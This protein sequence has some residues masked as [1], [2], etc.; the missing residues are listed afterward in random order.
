MRSSRF[1]LASALA[2]ASC[3]AN[4][5]IR[6]KTDKV[7][8]LIVGGSNAVG[9]QFNFIARMENGNNFCGGAL[10]D[11]QHVLTS[12]SCL[13]ATFTNGKPDMVIV[14][15]LND[16]SVKRHFHA[17]CVFIHPN[18]VPGDFPIA[19]IALV[20]L[21]STST[22]EP[23]PIN[24]NESYPSF[25]A[26]LKLLG[27]GSTSS[28]STVPSEI[29]QQLMMTFVD[30]DVCNLDHS[31]SLDR[32]AHFCAGGDIGEGGCFSDQGG[33][34]LGLNAPHT[35]SDYIVAGVYSFNSSKC[36][37]G[38]ADVFT[39]VAPYSIWINYMF[40]E[41]CP[42]TPMPSSAPS[43]S[44][45]PST[46][47]AP[48][49]SPTASPSATPSST[50]SSAPSS[51][52]TM[53]PTICFSED[54]TVNV[55]GQGEV[56]MKNLEVGHQVFAGYS[57]LSGIKTPVYET[58][59][60]FGHR[61][62]DKVAQ[63]LRVTTASSS[64][65]QPLEISGPHLIFVN[66]KKDPVRADSLQ[67]GDQL[68]HQSMED[69]TTTTARV[70]KIE[71]VLRRGLYQPL[72]ADGSILVDGLQASTYVSVVDLYPQVVQFGLNFFSEQSGFH[73][74]MAP[75]RFVCTKVAPQMCVND[76]NAMDD[77]ITHHLSFGKVLLELGE[78]LPTW[79]M[80]I[81]VALLATL[82]GL[83][84]LVDCLLE[85]DGR[86]VATVFSCLSVYWMLS[87]RRQ[88]VAGKAKVQ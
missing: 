78:W 86:V 14:G 88:R 49:S 20:K 54:A 58:V 69:G 60:G 24:E 79:L 41:D 34:L 13:Q 72:T 56:A 36:G 2:F 21:G 26:T 64:Q 77:G 61:E 85:G 47:L 68:V 9:N 81:G 53:E 70:T 6:A 35:G 75:Y 30:F 87:T 57:D 8:D 65:K 17:D 67:V 27:F 12:A 10:I 19:D 83:V 76:F 16:L 84:A 73:L 66:G 55:L 33:P 7:R 40:S 63:Y 52:P 18:F 15:S 46:S 11:E 82:C 74:W 28:S 39:P 50:P 32:D 5:G 59:Y 44:N 62:E 22:N 37:D 48:S 80:A 23:V 38:T 25:T 51:A 31:L 1:L 45:K 3:E 4:N 29:L 71:S 42:I 43:I